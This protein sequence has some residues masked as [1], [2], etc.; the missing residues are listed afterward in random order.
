MGNLC[1]DDMYKQ[2]K[3]KYPQDFQKFVEMKEIEKQI[4][5]KTQ[6]LQAKTK[7]SAENIKKENLS[8]FDTQSAQLKNH[9]R[10]L[11]ED[12]QQSYPGGVSFLESSKQVKL[13]ELIG[14]SE[15]SNKIK[16]MKANYVAQFD[17]Q[18]EK[19]NQEIKT[20]Q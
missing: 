10:A 9:Y 14:Y 18:Q 1:A 17:K 2:V 15:A 20:L 6:E 11:T 8:T 4:Q 13:E 19:V 3:E 5:T 16:D 7:E 12:V